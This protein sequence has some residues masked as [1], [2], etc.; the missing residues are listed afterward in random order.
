[1]ITNIPERVEQ[2]EEVGRLGRS[3]HVV[4]VTKVMMEVSV[5]EDK[6]TVPDWRKADWD[7]MRE[8]LRDTERQNWLLS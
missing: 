2:V 1:M 7:R 8:E 5:V 3:D 4:I 6:G